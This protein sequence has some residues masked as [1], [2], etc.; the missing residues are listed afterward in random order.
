[1]N[2][3]AQFDIPLTIGF[4]LIVT[5]VLTWLA[6]AIY[7]CWLALTGLEKALDRITGRD[8]V[9]IKITPHR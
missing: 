3:L 5:G 4:F 7:G 9:V 6:F 8:P 2:Y 1:M